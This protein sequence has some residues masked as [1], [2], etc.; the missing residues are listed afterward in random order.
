MGDQFGQVLLRDTMSL[1]PV[2]HHFDEESNNWGQKAKIEGKNEQTFRAF[3]IYSTRKTPQQ[4]STYGHTFKPM[5]TYGYT[6]GPHPDI[7]HRYPYLFERECGYSLPPVT[8][9]LW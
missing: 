3:T 7:W 8:D 6:L 5:C 4:D 2:Y 1:Q 9:K